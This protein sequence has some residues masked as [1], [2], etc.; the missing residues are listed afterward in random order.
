MGIRDFYFKR[1]WT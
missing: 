1:P